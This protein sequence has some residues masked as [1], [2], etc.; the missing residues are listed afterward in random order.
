MK[1]SI[2]SFALLVSVIAFF[3]CSGGNGKKQNQEGEQIAQLQETSFKVYGACGMCKNRIEK[4][5]NAVDGVQSAEWGQENN[6]LSFSYP[7]LK[8][9]LWKSM[10]SDS[11]IFSPSVFKFSH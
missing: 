11:A 8:I 7:K 3:A 9:F 4:A 1:K 5:A 10:L 2:F 6:I